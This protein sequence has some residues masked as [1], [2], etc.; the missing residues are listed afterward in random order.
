M[1]SEAGELIVTEVEKLFTW[2]YQPREQVFVIVYSNCEEVELKV[3]GKSLGRKSVVPDSYYAKFE[4]TYKSGKVE[5]IGYKDGKKVSHDQLLST[6]TSA[7]IVA[8][9][10]YGNLVCDGKDVAIIEVDI[11]DNKG[12]RVPEACNSIKVDVEGGARLLGVDSPNLFNKG[13]FTS[14]EREAQNGKLL[15]T[16]QSNG[17]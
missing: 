8:N 5:A 6:S 11:T 2:N 7:K 1:F 3:N 13:L 15:V 12:V 4:T 16:I 14:P 17:E 10:V 9:S